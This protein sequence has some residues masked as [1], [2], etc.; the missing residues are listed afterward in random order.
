MV[1]PFLELFFSFFEVSTF[2][3]LSLVTDYPLQDY[4]PKVQYQYQRY[5]TVSEIAPN[6][7]NGNSSGMVTDRFFLDLPTLD[8]LSVGENVN[9]LLT[10]E[11][12]TRSAIVTTNKND[13]LTKSFVYDFFL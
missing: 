5:S 4:P 12:D 8:A 7:P 2:L 9:T 13:I 10:G 6:V 3:L 11:N 1:S